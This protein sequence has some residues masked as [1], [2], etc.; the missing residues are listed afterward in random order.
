MRITKNKLTTLLSIWLSLFYSNI[1][2]GGTFS[3]GFTLS[4]SFAKKTHKVD[5][6]VIGGGASGTMAAIQSARMGVKTVLVEETTWL[7][8]MLTAAGVSAIDGNHQLPA[9]LWGEFRDSLIAHYGGAKALATG[10]V[11]HVLFEPSVGASILRNMINHEPKAAVWLETSFVSAAKT[12][13]GWIVTVKKDGKNEQIKTKILIDGTELGDVAKACGVKYDIG[14]D[15][16]SDYEEDIAPE[17]ANNIIQDL[18][19]VAILKDYGKGVDKTIPKPVNYDPAPFLCCCQ[20]KNCIQPKEENR[21]WSCDSMMT[22]GKLPHN[23]YMINWPIEGNDYYLNLIEMTPS[24]RQQSLEKAKQFT[25]SYIYYLQTEL[26]LNNLGLADDEFPTQDKL[27]FIPYY[28][29]SRRIHGLVRF[30][31]NHITHPFDQPEKLYRTGIAVGDY[32]VDHHHT[33]YHEW[34]KLP[35]L[36]FYPIPSYCLPMG[37]MLPKN[38]NNL[39]VAEKS[40]SV[41][42]LVNGTTRLQPVV[43]QIGQAA[44]IIAALAVKKKV[45]VSNVGVRNVQKELLKYKGYIMPYLDVRQTD[46][47][48]MPLQRIGATGILKGVSININWSNQTW[49][50]ANDPLL[51]NEIEGLFELYPKMQNKTPTGEKTTVKQAINLIKTIAA[52]EKIKLP[53]N[54]E[55]AAS[56]VLKN[57]NLNS[58][59]SDRAI[60]RKEMAV[61]I[62]YFLDSFTKKPIDI[63]GNFIGNEKNKIVNQYK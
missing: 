24:E 41:T 44:G 33:R 42:N 23:K 27:P 21:L 28:R 53:K 48:F 6:L 18:T 47:L 7:G 9:G 12:S 25:L 11:S 30:N 54:F 10:W 34:E 43:M 4:E 49:I 45:P 59:I 57:Y 1:A 36:H 38:V 46:P 29:E 14:M 35:D 60:L 40:I 52:I 3:E 62:D 16:R 39:I 50:R 20:S 26:D 55:Q 51:D 37:V 5:V 56:D 32:P 19:Y 22:Y 17:K 2:L 15:A 13:S 61:L 31:L 63:Y 58:T 8:G